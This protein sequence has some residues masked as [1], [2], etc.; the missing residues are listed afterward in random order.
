[1]V[2]I[3]RLYLESGLPYKL[4]SIVSVRHPL[5]RDILELG[6]NGESIYWEYV[7]RILSDPYQ[8]MVWLDDN[9]IDYEDVDCFDVFCLQWKYLSNIYFQNKSEFDQ[10]GFNP[11]ITIA[12]ALDFFF[13]ENHSY[14]LSSSD[15]NGTYIEDPFVNGFSINREE[16]LSFSA[17][18]QKIN[19]ISFDGRIKPRD[20]IAKRILIEDMRDELS[21]KRHKSKSTETDEGSSFLGNMVASVLH[22]GNGAI[23]TFNFTEAPIFSIISAY[24]VL[25][26]KANI[27]HILTGVYSGT[28]K[29]DALK[30]T[31]MDWAT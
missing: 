26:T 20:K 22:G 23:N 6:R 4:N 18:V 25:H 31:N 10:S 19:G 27:N 12:T 29:S 24:K 2:E 16:Y 1:M 7:G 30:N 21:R 28:V 15:S 11:L 9:G 8:N 17:F 3:D 5:L 13:G 14:R